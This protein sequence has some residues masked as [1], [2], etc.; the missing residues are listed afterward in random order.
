MTSKPLPSTPQDDRAF[1][2]LP[3]RREPWGCRGPPLLPALCGP[4]SCLSASLPTQQ[5]AACLQAELPQVPGL[6]VCLS[7]RRLLAH[8]RVVTQG[9]AASSTTLGSSTRPCQAGVNSVSRWGG[10]GS[11][12]RETMNQTQAGPSS[13]GATRTLRWAVSQEATQS[14]RPCFSLSLFYS[15]V[16]ALIIRGRS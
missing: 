7:V 6:G 16:A 11:Y 12:R 9:P 10:R 14:D 15:R 5:Q 8:P 2:A 1:R 13:P 4:S 3:P